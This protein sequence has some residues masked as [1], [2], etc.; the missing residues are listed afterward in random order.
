M[1]TRSRVT[2]QNALSGW[3]AGIG[4]W[5]LGLSS[6]LSQSGRLFNHGYTPRPDDVFIATAPKSGTTLMQMMLYQLTTDGSMAFPH[7]DSVSPFFELDFLRGAPP[8]FHD[9]LPSP[10]IFKTHLRHEHLPPGAPRI[11][12]MLRDVWDVTVSSY[13][14]EVLVN[15]MDVDLD[16]FLDRYLAG[17]T[18]FVLWFDH[19]ESWWPHRRDPNVL[20]LRYEEAVRDLEGTVRKVAAFCGIPIDEKEMP[21]ILERCGVEFMRRHDDKFDPR[22]RRVFGEPGKFIREG[23][24]GKGRQA[25]SERHREM[26]AQRLEALAKKLGT[27]ESELLEGP[28]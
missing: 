6:R 28:S 4:H 8:G 12:Y 22:M 11:V 15:G 18:R 17:Q 5:T 7:I 16:P 13:H 14:H 27:S 10:R 24:S 9:R 25:L 21:R 20:F 23:K 3:L 2:L 26:I 1:I 19:L